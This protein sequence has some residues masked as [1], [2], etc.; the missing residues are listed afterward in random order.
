MEPRL[1]PGVGRTRR[2]EAILRCL[3][4]LD[5]SAALS[6]SWVRRGALG[7]T[8]ADLLTFSVLINI[9]LA[10]VNLF[11]LPPLDG[12]R[13]LFCVLEKLY[14][15]AAKV[16]TPVTVA[17]WA[18]VMVLMVYLTIQDVGRLVA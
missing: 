18:L 16:E 4:M 14:R 5:R 15:P 13:V 6:A 8:L 12:G 17:G 2:T 11:P 3:P 7:S 10:V 9:S 1:L